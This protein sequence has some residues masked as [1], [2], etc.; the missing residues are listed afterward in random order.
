MQLD[1]TRTELETK[2]SALNVLR[3]GTSEVLMFSDKEALSR[4]HL[5]TRVTEAKIIRPEISTLGA[6]HPV[7][8]KDHGQVAEMHHERSRMSHLD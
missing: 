7:S 3:R 8:R 6:C 1:R 4:R 5:L 2:P